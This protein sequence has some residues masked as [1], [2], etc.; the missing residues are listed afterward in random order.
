MPEEGSFAEA[1]VRLRLSRGLSQAELARQLKEYE[2]NIS[3]WGRGGGIEL[4]KVRK[5]ADFFGVDRGWL[6]GLAGYP[7]GEA[8]AAT[9]AVQP[10]LHARLARL[11]AKLSQCPRAVWLA[12]MDANE[13]LA[14]ALALQAPR[15]T[16]PG[17]QPLDN[18]KVKKCRSGS[19][20]PY[21][22]Q[23]VSEQVLRYGFQPAVI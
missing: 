15:D 8:T 19:R 6:E 14:E 3:R 23:S 1:F 13:R 9:V 12:F 22:R 10:E 20:R 17:D 7:L 21:E 5:I 16:P 4:V 11:E 18:S 2:G